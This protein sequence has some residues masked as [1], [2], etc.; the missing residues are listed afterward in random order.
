MNMEQGLK[1]PPINT[2]LQV[3]YGFKFCHVDWQ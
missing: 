2:E 1:E 3:Y